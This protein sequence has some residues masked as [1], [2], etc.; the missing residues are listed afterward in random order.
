MKLSGADLR[1]K[2]QRGGQCAG[3]SSR[4][5]TGTGAA[6][7]KICCSYSSVRTDHHH[8]LTEHPGAQA[9]GRARSGFR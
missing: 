4:C 8:R 2:S 3:V 9:A 5:L 7:S 6:S 1:M